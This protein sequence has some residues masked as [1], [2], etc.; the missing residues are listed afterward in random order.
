M[1]GRGDTL[2]GYRIDDVIGMGGMAIVYRAEQVSL[3][4]AVALKVLSPQ[5]SRDEEFR[6]RFRREGKHAAALHHPNVVTIF[7]SGEAD[8]RL[9]LAML[10]VEGTTLAEKMSSERLSADETLSVLAPIAS[11]LD[12][13]HALGLVHRDVK[14][15]NILLD[16]G[17]RPYLAD[18]GIAKGS[19]ATAGLTATGGF[20]GS[21]N[22]AAP[23]Q[24][25]GEPATAATDVYALAAVLYQCLTGQVP[26]PRD[27][28]ASVMYA[29]LHEPPPR[30]PNRWPQA[31]E[32]SNVI[33]RGLAKQP[34]DRYPEAGQLMEDAAALIAGMPGSLHA[35]SPPFP[36]TQTSGHGSATGA[37]PRSATSYMAGIDPTAV[38]PARRPRDH[39]T[40]TSPR[41][42]A[43]S[44]RVLPPNAGDQTTA[45]RHRQ[46][47]GR[48]PGGG[49]GQSPPQSS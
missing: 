18:F 27:T 39:E 26:Y 17:A 31:G 36:M 8:G 13:A 11:A 12:A 35:A 33:A 30:L 38:Q 34:S 1:L 23:E 22:Y 41:A 15:Q 14:P 16:R 45:D 3:G 10:L 37:D 5:L 28:D 32:L 6:E 46:T 42:S 19:A 48:H 24:I 29:Q 40:A 4:R 2:A 7:D 21:L 25:R 49:C 47:T 9:F 20:V 43:R 44:A